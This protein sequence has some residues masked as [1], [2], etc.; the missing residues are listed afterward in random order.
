MVSTSLYLKMYL[1][2]H[3][4]VILPEKRKKVNHIAPFDRIS[5]KCYDNAAGEMLH[6]NGRRFGSHH[7]KGGD[8]MP[9]TLTFH[10]FGLVITLKVKRE[11]R[12]S[13]K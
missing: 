5:P 9:F 7:P 4:N 3:D 11:N 10:L 8:L 12:H 2:R 6:H 13:A 1:L